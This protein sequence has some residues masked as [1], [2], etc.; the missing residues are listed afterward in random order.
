[1]P[2]FTIY[3]LKIF[4]NFFFIFDVVHPSLVVND[5]EE[6]NQESILR[7]KSLSG[8]WE[9][10]SLFTTFLTTT[11][12]FTLV[13]IIFMSKPLHNWTRITL[14]ANL[15]LNVHKYFF[16]NIFK[17]WFTTTNLHCELWWPSPGC[18]SLL[19]K[20]PAQ[21]GKGS[22]TSAWPTQGSRPSHH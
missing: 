9:I 16:L 18:V 7:R 22:W 17:V 19:G 6:G 15:Y 3:I 8:A 12:N 5:S 20:F 1:M 13:D 11:D 10:P 21:S 2:A 14:N 4:C